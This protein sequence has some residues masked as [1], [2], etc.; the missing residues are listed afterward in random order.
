VVVVVVDDPEVVV[1]AACD[2]VVEP[3]APPVAEDVL[4]PELPQAAS[5]SAADNAS[6]VARILRL[7]RITP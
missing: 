4:L 3:E 1:V 2:A 5:R 7:S 6:M